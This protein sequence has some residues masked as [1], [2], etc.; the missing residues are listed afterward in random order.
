MGRYRASTKNRANKTNKQNPKLLPTASILL[1]LTH[2]TSEKSGQGPLKP[3]HVG[4]EAHPTA[5]EGGRAPRDLRAKSVSLHTE[6]NSSRL[7]V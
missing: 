2:T 4:R 7:L 5:P 3:L 6:S 1:N